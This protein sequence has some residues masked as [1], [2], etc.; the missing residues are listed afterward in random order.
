MLRCAISGQAARG[1]WLDDLLSRLLTF[2]NVLITS[3]QG[4]L[5][6]EALGEI[7]RVTVENIGR[8]ATGGTFLEGT[9]L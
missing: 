1:A 4:F 3:H 6:R 2:P 5:T 7:T 8:L 9:T